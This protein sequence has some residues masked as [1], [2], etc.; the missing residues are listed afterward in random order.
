MNANITAVGK[1]LPKK[2]IKNNRLTLGF[3]KLPEINE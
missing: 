3:K 2:V 1:F